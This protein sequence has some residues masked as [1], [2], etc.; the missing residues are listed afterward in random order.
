[1]GPSER[2]PVAILGA[3]L[4]GVTAAV[5]LRQ[6]GIPVRLYEAGKRIAGL[7]ASFH[8]KDGF[9]NDFG[10]HFI[11][12]RLAA[13]VGVGA[14]C[15][16][17]RH[18]G[19]A[20]LLRGKVY[21][22]PLG[23]MRNPRFLLSGI[24]GRLTG[25]RTPSPPR[26]VAEWFRA[27]FGAALA[28]DVAIPLIEAWSGVSADLLAPTAVSE[29]LQHGIS[30]TLWLRLAGQ[31]TRRAVANGYSHE[32]PERPSV[33]HVYPVGGV[34]VLVQRLADGLGDA[35][36]LESPI[37]GIVVDSGRAVAVRV[38]GREE[39]VAAVIS[40]APCHVLPRITV[41]SDALQ[42]LARFRFR[43]MVFVNLRLRGRGLLPD[44]VLWTPEKDF[45][46]FRVTET[47]RSM[48][49]LAP[50]GKTL[51][52]VDLGCEAQDPTWSMPDDRLAA[53][54]VEALA[55]IIPDIRQRFLGAQVL[56]TPIA[57]PLF[58][59]EY[60][61]DRLRLKQSTGVEGLYSIGR[62]GE[63]AHILMEDVYWRTLARVRQVARDLQ[64]AS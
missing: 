10:A 42:P 47:T 44:T 43:P 62:N 30:R 19:E 59:N 23:L 21:S 20:V 31:L 49:W 15:R 40:T 5:A 32:M 51:L 63:F 29:K 38:H 28:K 45:P 64:A 33:W 52:T 60:E 2:R 34:S 7:A 50:P 8:D 35:I 27:A 14:C 12:N 4:A 25:G 24:A 18:Y 57:Y 1:M 53:T 13:A 22:Y 61:T 6:R 39:E 26:S 37:E 17:V 3:G 56:R 36:Q 11:T 55:P 41:G 54:C 9:T 46:F 16:D 48:P 58:L